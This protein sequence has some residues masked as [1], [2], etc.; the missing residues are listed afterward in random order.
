MRSRLG[1]LCFFG[2]AVFVVHSYF[3]TS[4]LLASVVAFRLLLQA[5]LMFSRS[6]TSCSTRNSASLIAWGSALLPLAYGVSHVPAIASPTIEDLLQTALLLGMLL[7][8]WGYYSLGSSFGISPSRRAFVTHGAFRWFRHPIYAGYVLCE[9]SWVALEPSLRNFGVY[10]L[11]M[12]LY[13]LRS[14]AENRLFA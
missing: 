2:F 8:T 5:L 1:S 9:T 6:A 4:P 12:Q 3:R 7:S 13:Q 14:R 11:S 10:L